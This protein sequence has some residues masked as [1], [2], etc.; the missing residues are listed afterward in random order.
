MEH[1]DEKQHYAKDYLKLL[2]FLSFFVTTGVLFVLSFRESSIVGTFLEERLFLLILFNVNAGGHYLFHELFKKRRS[3]DIVNK[4]NNTTGIVS[5]TLLV[6]VAFYAVIISVKEITALLILTN[7]IS[8]IVYKL[9]SFDLL[10]FVY[11]TTLMIVLIYSVRESLNKV[12]PKTKEVV[13]MAAL[14]WLVKLLNNVALRIVNHLFSVYGPLSV[15]ISMQGTL[16]VVA[17]IFNLSL[18]VCGLI[19]I[20]KNKFPYGKLWLGL[21]VVQVINFAINLL[22][23]FYQSVSALRVLELLTL[24]NIALLY[25]KLFFVFLIILAYEKPYP[26]QEVEY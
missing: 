14:I 24:I 26:P 19:I 2:V 1:I 8:F 15:L 20:F 21:A 18:L 3:R 9:H 7:R 10:F 11:A 5:L 25:A 13:N 16:S 4:E 23:P 6:V 22:L 12:Y 17:L